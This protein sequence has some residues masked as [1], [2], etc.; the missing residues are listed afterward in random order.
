M[1]FFLDTGE[2][3]RIKKYAEMGLCDGITTNPSLIMKSGRDHKQVIQEIAD[4]VSGPISVEAIGSTAEEM[5]KEAEEF[6]TWAQNVVIKVPMTQEGLKAARILE[7]SGTPVNVTLVFSAAQALLAAKAGASY[8]S[9]FIGRLDDRGERGMDLIQDIMEIF[10]NHW[11]KT[12]VIVASIRSVKHI[13]EAAKL[14]AHIA[15]IPPK[16]MD[17][18]WKHELTDKGIERFL[19]DYKKS[20]EN[21]G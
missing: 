13:E 1:K 12:Q 2:V 3:D 19:E 18:M 17:E 16:I 11:I 10:T 7:N 6:K 15:T 9:P 5:L 4:I 21:K 20:L 14:G 8:V